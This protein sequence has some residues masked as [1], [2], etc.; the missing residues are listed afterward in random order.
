MIV[1]LTITR[2][3]ENTAMTLNANTRVHQNPLG[4]IAV[5]KAAARIGP[6]IAP[7]PVRNTFV[8]L[9]VTALPGGSTSITWLSASEYMV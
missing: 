2:Y 5:I 9:A 7:T 6:I 4:P 3:S 1:G 8:E